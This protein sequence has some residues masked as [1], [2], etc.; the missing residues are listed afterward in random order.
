MSARASLCLLAAALLAGCGGG[1]HR[2]QPAPPAASPTET[3]AEGP[4]ARPAKTADARD[5]PT[6]DVTPS[7]TGVFTGPTPIDAG[8]VARLRRQRVR[9]PGTVDSA[10]IYLHAVKVAGKRRNVFVMTTTYGRTLAV[11]AASGRI[12]WTFTPRGYASWAGTPQITQAGPT[13]DSDRRHVFT[14]SPDG[15]L[16]RLT[17][18]DGREASGGRWPV[19]LTRDPR[20]EKLTSSLNLIGNR[21]VMTT[22]GYIGD[23]PPYQGHVVVLDRVSGR[24]ESVFYALC[25]DFRRIRP[26]TACPANI[27]AIWGRAGAVLTP[28]RSVLVSTGNGPFDHRRNWGDTVLELSLDGLRLRHT[29]TPA[30]QRELEASDAD[31]GSTSPVVVPGGV[32]Q[33]GKFGVLDVLS[34]QLR[35]LQQLRNPGGT[36]MFTAPA[37]WTRRGRTTVFATTGAGTEALSW[38]GR[39][40]RRL[41][42][43]GEGGTSPMLAGGLLYVYDP[44]GS[45]VVRNPVNGRVLA[46]LP[47]GSGH[48]NSPIVGGGVVALPEGNG[49]D[50]ATTGTLSL[51]RL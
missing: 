8:N 21:L 42:S 25:S 45:L 35:H 30:N 12:L 34:T 47:A 43:S 9:L 36:A 7:R 32:L 41:W 24:I 16:H 5:W 22:G 10:P 28:R 48:W 38:S 37:V 17:L 46:R 15:R 26:P 49:N 4:A 11:D 51:Y 39:R 6:F 14:A 3:A 40:L 1:G 13:A 31:L 50:H 33:S 20:H 29:W 18:S 23:A 2:A 44:S 27:A 19:S